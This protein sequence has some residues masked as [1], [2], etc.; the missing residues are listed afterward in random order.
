MD[1]LQIGKIVGT[2]GLKGEVRVVPL[3]DNPDRFV[4]MKEVNVENKGVITKYNL[5]SV[6]F[7]KNLVVLKLSGIDEINAAE[8]MRES[9]LIVDRKDAVKLP[10]NSFFICDLI[11]LK[12]ID[13]KGDFLGNL[14][15]VLSTGS[16]DVYII[17]DEKSVNCNG[18][19]RKDILIPALKSVVTEVS[20]E[21]GTMKVQLPK[22][23][24][25]DEV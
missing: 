16:N 21:A 6:K 20:T 11:G 14:V 7:L 24:L 25:D 2:H 9:Y 22:G 8:A 23:L 5:E 12:V 17:R 13:E 10:K 1:Y 3:T 19:K 18:A 4:G 15:E